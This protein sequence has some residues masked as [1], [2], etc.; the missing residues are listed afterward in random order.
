MDTKSLSFYQVRWAQK[1]FRYYFCI[2]DSQGKANK[3]ANTLSRYPQRSQNKEKILQVE[4]TRI[5][6]HLQSLLTNTR[7]FSTLPAY[8]LYLKHQ[9]IQ[10]TYALTN[11]CL[12][13]EI[14]CQEL[15]TECFYQAGIRGIRPRLMGLQR[16]NGQVRKIRVENWA[17]SKKILIESCIIKAYST[18]LKSS[19]LC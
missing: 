1:L 12:F 11:L 18:F 14:F 8:V 16:E 7:M 17:E 4:N 10:G 5:L 6:Q 15:D 19:E 3:A 13:Q 2:N 9:I